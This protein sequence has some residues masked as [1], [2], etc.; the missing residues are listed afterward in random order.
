MT[1]AYNAG[2]RV[3]RLHTGDPALY[4]AIAEQIAALKKQ[5]VPF[6]VFPGVTAAFAASASMGIEY[7]LPEVTQTLILTRM[8]GRTPVPEAEALTSLAK[9]QASMSIY[10]SISMIDKV[11]EILKEAYG[12]NAPAAVAYCVS[13]PEEQI[14]RTTVRELPAVV[15]REK[16]RKTALIIVGHALDPARQGETRKSKLYDKN[17]SHEYRQKA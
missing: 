1:E 6:Q 3:V 5:D 14:F 11:T 10:L 7:T 2:S 9:H 15:E 17:F 12:E 16:I 4:G 8:A 13:Q